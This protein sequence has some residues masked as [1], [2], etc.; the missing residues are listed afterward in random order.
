LSQAEVRLAED[1]TLI[2]AGAYS[3]DVPR[4]MAHT[5]SVLG[6][7]WRSMGAWMLPG[8]FTAGRPGADIHYAGTLP[9]ARDPVRGQTSTEGAVHGLPGVFVV[10]GACLPALPEKSHTLTLMAN[11][12]R[13]ARRLVHSRA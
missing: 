3:E 10:D 1:G 11:A 9:M 12:D 2:V 8:S 5:R 7:A 13:I 6:R 4:L